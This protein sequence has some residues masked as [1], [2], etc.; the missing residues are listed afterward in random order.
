MTA[1]DIKDI[2]IM[3]TN[4]AWIIEQSKTLK[5]LFSYGSEEMVKLNKSRAL[6]TID[7]I[8]DSLNEL[9]LYIESL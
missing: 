4:C 6:S 2:L 5:A 9:K 3:K 1:T 8:T 7:T